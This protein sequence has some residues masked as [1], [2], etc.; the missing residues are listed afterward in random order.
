MC[1]SQKPHIAQLHSCVFA[2][3]FIHVPIPYVIDEC[4]L[5][6]SKLFFHALFWFATF[7]PDN[8]QTECEHFQCI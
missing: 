4:Q 7:N 3:P 2:D 1:D 6:K 8:T 5:E